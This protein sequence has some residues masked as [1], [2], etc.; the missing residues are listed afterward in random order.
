[1]AQV[2]I[3]GGAERFEIGR[4]ISTSIAVFIRNLVPFCIISLVIGIPYILVTLWSAGGAKDL[5][6]AAQTGQVPSGFWGMIAIGVLIFMLTNALTQSAIVYGTFQDL[7]GQKASFGDC[8]ARGLAMLPRVIGAAILASIGIMI[9]GLLLVI[10]GIMLTVMWWVYVPAVVVEGAGVTESLGR[11]RTLTSGHGW[12]IFGLLLIVGV[13]E[14]AI[15]YLLGLIT[16]AFGATVAG[17]VDIVVTL[18]FSA[19]ASVMS[20]VGYYYLRAEKEGVIVE[21][22]AKVFD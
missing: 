5:E 11:S 18:V 4:V 19:L 7:R 8:L 17:I 12:G 16:P 9:G 3:S 21:D 6:A 15:S 10:P 13:A 1:M 22:I 20:A 14:G 2:G